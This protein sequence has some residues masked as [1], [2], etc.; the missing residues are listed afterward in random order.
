MCPFIT[1]LTERG[2]RPSHSQGWTAQ[3]RRE[4]H[5]TVQDSIR[6]IQMALKRLSDR[7][8]RRLRHI[9]EVSPIDFIIAC[10]LKGVSLRP[11]AVV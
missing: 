2:C 8:T 9:A 6:A 10:L 5:A 11:I 1:G 3:S 4:M 7:F